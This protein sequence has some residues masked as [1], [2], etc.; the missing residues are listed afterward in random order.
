[1]W[2]RSSEG[3]TGREGGERA[4]KVPIEG[5]RREKFR[6]GGEK[7]VD[8]LGEGSEVKLLKKSRKRAIDKATEQEKIGTRLKKHVDGKNQQP[9]R[10]LKTNPPQKLE[11]S[12]TYTRKTNQKKSERGETKRGNARF[13]H[14]S[15]GLNERRSRKGMDDRGG[16]SKIQEGNCSRT[17]HKGGRHTRAISNRLGNRDLLPRLPMIGCSTNWTPA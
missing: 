6:K 7:K 17:D 3:G 2:T 11:E 16:K 9:R 10:P 13:L 4:R 14:K 15:I 8:R 12:P 1:M 5:E